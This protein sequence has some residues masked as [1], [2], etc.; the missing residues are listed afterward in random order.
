MASKRTPFD[1]AANAR[2]VGWSNVSSCKVLAPL[3]ARIGNVSPDKGMK[4]I[5]PRGWIAVASNG[6]LW[7]HPKRR[8]TSEEWAR[9]FAIAV[10]CFGFE[11]VRR[12]PPQELWELASLLCAD[13][14]CE[15]LKIGRLPDELR[16]VP[17]PIPVG[18]EDPLFRHFCVQG[19]DQELLGWR[20]AFSGCG[21][22]FHESDVHYHY[23]QSQKGTWRDLLAEGV[24]QGAGEAIRRTVAK[25]D[26]DGN[27]V[28]LSK[29]QKARLRLINAYPLVGAMGVDFSLEEDPRLC[30]A[31]KV[32]VGAIDVAAKKIWLN[33][34]AGLSEAEC[35]FVLAHELLHAGLAHASRRRGRDP[36]L[37]NV[38][39]DFIING[40]LVEMG[41]G[42]AP[43]M[44]MLLDPA[45]NGMSAEDVYDI[46]ATDMR[47]ARKLATLRGVGEP[48]M[49]GED[50]GPGF[51]D[52]EAFCKRALYL[53]MERCLSGETRGLLPAGLVEEIR[54]LAQP[55]IP[56]DVQLAEWFD[57]RFPLPE[58]R[59]SYA[60][61]SRRQAATPDIPR[62]SLAKPSEEE[63]KARVFAVLLDTSGSMS[64][65]CL[66]QALGAIGSYAL[67]RDVYSVRLICCDAHAYDSGWIE[68]E[69]LLYA[70]EIKGRGGTILQPGVDLLQRSIETNDFPKTGP[71]LV[72]TDGWCESK[73]DIPLEHAFLLPEGR[74]LPFAPRGKVFWIGEG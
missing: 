53:G 50:S 73:L 28:V 6:T 19:V 45:F 41:V 54:S 69:R 29:A 61:P 48:D 65:K 62:P 24:I 52:A 21:A 68:P 4:C 8:A 66:G 36:F 26:R 5:S 57:E 42:V 47:R 70:V 15:E 9:V 74:R 64:P 27:E 14:F 23:L 44:G 11:M 55:P 43:A 7:A 12:R 18:G 2:D 72:I 67:A 60:R 59:R 37:W 46:L 34:A 10:V 38:A 1:E 49:L 3:A 40:W 58:R 13:R 17:F 31:Y 32:R 16:Y 56:W 22:L 71:L 20:A 25:K 63:R 51:V 33:P 30:Q 39:C 35:L